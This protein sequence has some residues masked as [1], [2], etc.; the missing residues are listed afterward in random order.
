MKTEIIIPSSGVID[1]Y[2]D[3][4]LSLNYN[5]ANVRTPEKRNADFSKTIIVPGTDNN[6]NL[7]A[8]IFEIGVDR[9]FNPNRKTTAELVVDKTA[10]M[11]G[12]L[13]LARIKNLDNKRIEYELE[14]KGRVDDL[15]TSIKDLLLT[16]IDWSDLNHTW[17]K[18][19]IINS[20]SATVGEGYVY[21]FIDYG[22]G[23]PPNT[24]EVTGFKPATYVKEIID[25]IFALAGFQYSSTFFNTDFFKRLIIP[26]NSDKFLA[27]SDVAINSVF[28]ASR[29]S[30]QAFT[31]SPAGL[32]DIIFNNDSTSPNSDAGNNYN[33]ATGVFT[34]PVN[35]TYSFNTS[36]PIHFQGDP[37]SATFVAFAWTVLYKNGVTIVNSAGTQFSCLIGEPVIHDTTLINTWTG[38]LFAGETI[39][40][41]GRTSNSVGGNYSNQ[42]NYIASGSFIYNALLPQVLVNSAFSYSTALPQTLKLEDFLKSIIRMFNLYFEYDKD[43][44]NKIYIEPRNDFYNTTIQDWTY[45][46]DVSKELI[47]EPMGA[48][49]A[50]RYIFKYKQDKDWLNEVYQSTYNQVDGESYGVRIKTV[51]NDF[52]KNDYDI[53]SDVIFSPTPQYSNADSDRVYPKIIKLDPQTNVVSPVT[54]N[55]RIL[56]YGGLKS[57][58]SWSFYSIAPA[59]GTTHTTYPYCGHISDPQNPVYDLSWGVP[60]QIYY[61][62]AFAATYTNNNLYNVYWKKFIDE[63][64]DKNSSIVTGWFHLTPVDIAALDFRHIYRFGFQNYRLNKIYDFN[65]VKDE[66]TKCE[67]IKT[68]DAAPFVPEDIVIYGGRDQIFGGVEPGPVF[69]LPTTKEMP[70]EL[71]N[72]PREQVTG[73]GNEIGPKSI[74]VIIAGGNN[75][76]GS[77]SQNV[78]LLGSSGNT[79]LGGLQNVILLNTSGVTV[80]E[81]NVIYINGA[82]WN[83]PCPIPKTVAE[84]Q[85]MATSGTINPCGE[86]LITDTYN[87]FGL[88]RIR[89][90]TATQLEPE[91]TLLTSG[92]IFE[93]GYDLT[94]N[95]LTSITDEV[96]NNIILNA[97]GNNRGGNCIEEF[98]KRHDSYRNNKGTGF[99]LA[100]TSSGTCIISGCDFGVYA[101][102][103]LSG[104][105]GTAYIQ[106]S[107]LTGG[108]IIS[109]NGSSV[110]DLH[111]RESSQAYLTNASIISGL[112]L[113]ENAVAVMDHSNLNNCYL[114][115]NSIVTL[116]Y[117][118]LTNCR[119]ED[120]VTVSFNTESYSGKVLNKAVSTFNKTID[121]TGG[122][123]INFASGSYDRSFAGVINLTTSN[124]FENINAVSNF[125]YTHDVTFYGQAGKI[126]RFLDNP[127]FMTLNGAATASLTSANAFIKFRI[128]SNVAYELYRGI[129]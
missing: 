9:L 96:Q 82:K 12:I 2:E 25:R 1:L 44:P 73:I 100:I 40:V 128:E 43:V 119:I 109:I 62:P 77:G 3:V 41:R 67:F 36:I 121:I 72:P 55:L 47:I 94:Y 28:R 17:N 58:Q 52:L 29:T 113:R 27:E 122:G 4:A 53:T 10:V 125:N 21:P 39:Q 7:L 81:S 83:G 19:D 114:D 97:A 93:V 64:T 30:N 16:D 31:Y 98:P 87:N 37:A 69:N 110:S 126:L 86:Y 99:N 23:F 38:F 76:V 48:L 24:M 88:L 70:R 104:S 85:L 117:T 59:D 120:G 75:N 124:G 65:P 35:G 127:G 56:Y 68:R 84:M 50:K 105:S 5:I 103:T 108:P 91:G 101:T 60:K 46:Q 115:G 80:T 95:Q 66:L 22:Y 33:P 118:D 51:E 8:H 26:F 11:K 90:R 123:T 57:C 14:L 54:A 42:N 45:K 74:G 106:N 111:A 6:N 102:L 112:T 61:T 34:A 92:T 116:F 13:R 20:W 79:I 71:V 78:I 89:G 18:T 107:T 15:F 32:F 129:Y 49:E 63:I